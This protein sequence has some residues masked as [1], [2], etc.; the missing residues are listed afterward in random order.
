MDENYQVNHKGQT[1]ASIEANTAEARSFMRPN[2]SFE[3][4][5]TPNEINDTGYSI[6]RDL[7]EQ[8]QSKKFRN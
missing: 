3:E 6:S 8:N 5:H 4:A 7:D 1:R 2:H